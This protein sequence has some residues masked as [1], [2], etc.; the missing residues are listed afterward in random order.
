VIRRLCARLLVAVL[1][2]VGGL[3]LAEGALRLADGQPILPLIRPLPY[4]DNGALYRRTPRR[5]YELRPGVD[6]TVGR[7]GIHIHINAAGF[8]DDVEYPLAKPSGTAR[9]VVLGDSFTFGGKVTLEETYP[10]VVGKRLDVVDPGHR[11]EVLNLAVPGYNTEQEALLFEEKGLAYE[12]DLVLVGFVLND[13]ASMV[14]LVPA[15]EPRFPALHSFLKRLAVVQFLYGHY[16]QIRMGMQTGRWSR[17]SVDPDFMPDTARWALTRKALQRIATLASS[18]GARTLVVVWPMLDDLDDR[19]AHLAKHQLVA[20]TCR[21]LGIPVLD[22]LPSFRGREA[23]TLWA[24]TRDHHPNAEAQRIAAAAIVEA[25]VSDGV[26]RSAPS[27]D[28][29]SSS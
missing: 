19:Y 14:Q 16:K 3:V 27:T 22:L 28:R 24:E 8:R 10:K 6:D 25:I 20:D 2:L 12:P 23:P 1:G 7:R 13:A 5:L 17:S 26:I 29:R 11:H 4:I 9:V 18:R 15:R 21:E